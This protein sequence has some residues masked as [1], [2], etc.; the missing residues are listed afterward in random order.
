MSDFESE[1]K[2]RFLEVKDWAEND[3]ER[4][5]ISWRL[6]DY[7]ETIFYPGDN[8]RDEYRAKEFEINGFDED[9]FKFYVEATAGTV[10]WAR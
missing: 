8:L 4:E 2:D 6:R 10:N 5:E 7:L 3:E 9:D 1:F